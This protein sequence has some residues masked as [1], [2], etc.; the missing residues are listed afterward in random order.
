MAVWWDLIDTELRLKT[1]KFKNSSPK[2]VD[3]NGNEYVKFTQVSNAVN[4]L[5]IVNATTGNGAELQATGDDTNIDV[6]LVPK[7]TG[8]VNMTGE[9]AQVAATKAYYIGAPGTDGS[10]RF[11]VSGADLVIQKRVTGSWVTKSTI[12]GA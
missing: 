2:I 6:K 5:T 10:W 11:I 8:V 3:E 12:S 9:G 4:E 1:L 7:G